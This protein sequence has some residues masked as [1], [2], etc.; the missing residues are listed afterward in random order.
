MI[1]FCTAFAWGILTKWAADY[2]GKGWG[3]LPKTLVAQILL[4]Y[5]LPKGVL[6][7]ATGFLSDRV[8]RRWPVSV[9]L[10]MCACAFVYLAVV[11]VTGTSDAVVFGN[12]AGGAAI[13]G[14]GTA[15]MYPNL[16][17]AVAEH[18]DP[19]WRASC[20]GTYRFWRDLGYAVGGFVLGAAADRSSAS[21]SAGV[22][23]VLTFVVSLLFG[24]WYRDRVEGALDMQHLELGIKEGGE[25]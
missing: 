14:V 17:G 23:A 24:V 22:G 21:V 15:V 4:A 7:F 19:T 20:V 11:G 9:G 3:P 16:I 25:C 6:Q 18:A 10:L 8:G 2:G 5:S 12:F 1:N 13:L